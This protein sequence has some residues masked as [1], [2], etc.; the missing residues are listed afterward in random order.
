MQIR[1]F[2]VL[3][4]PFRKCDDGS[5]KYA[6]FKRS[7]HEYWQ[8]IAGGGMGGESFLEGAKRESQEEANIP[9]YAEYFSLET[10]TSVAI[11]HFADPTPMG[12][13]V[14]NEHCFAVD[15][16]DIEIILS[17]EHSQYQWVDYKSAEK[18]LHWDGNKTAIW[19]LNQRLTDNKMIS[20]GK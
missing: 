2:Q 6:I 20:A 11:H 18:M 13:Y 5:F 8:A 10:V 7:D 17:S 14:I 15:C 4:F 9:E 12:K 3:I 16:S 19:E 1:S